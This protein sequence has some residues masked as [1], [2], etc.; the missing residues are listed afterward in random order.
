MATVCPAIS[1][2]TTHDPLGIGAMF[3]SGLLHSG[4]RT[5]WLCRWRQCWFLDCGKGYTMTLAT[6][7]HKFAMDVWHTTPELKGYSRRLWRGDPAGAEDGISETVCRALTASHTFTG[8][9]PCRVDASDTAER[10]R[11]PSG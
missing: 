5:S 1:G 11:G 4:L 7:N 9:Q 6:A 3:L 10:P 8:G 2:R